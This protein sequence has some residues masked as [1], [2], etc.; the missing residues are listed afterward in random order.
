MEINLKNKKTLADINELF[1]ERNNDIKFE[2]GYGPII[3][4]AKRKVAEEL[5]LEPEPSKAKTK[6]KKSLLKLPEEFINEIK[7]DKKIYIGKY[8]KNSFLSY[9]ITFSILM[10]H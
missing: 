3:L 6:R 5:E 9:S 7:N 10:M 1:N 2:D 4:E 8:L